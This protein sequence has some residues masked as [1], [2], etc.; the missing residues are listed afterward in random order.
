MRDNPSLKG[1]VAVCP[2]LDLAAGAV[3]IDHWSR[4]PYLNH[5]LRA[6][7]EIYAGVATQ[8]RD[9]PISVERAKQIRSI[10]V[11]DDEVVAPWH[12]FESAHDYYDRVAVAKHLP[13]M[14][15]PA[16]VVVGEHDPRI[17]HAR[18]AAVA[19]EGL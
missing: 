15:K 10:R 7:T 17:P 11:W 5:M 19:R 14:S 12:G 4:R 6:L 18:G 2:P 1:V 3:E 16:L 13:T 8:R 9:V